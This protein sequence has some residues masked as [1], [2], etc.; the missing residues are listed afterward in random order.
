MRRLRIGIIGA[1]ALTEWA[2]LP[3]LSGPDA[4]A[5]PDTGAWSGRRP[6]THA[7]IRYQAPAQPDVVALCDAD[8]GLARRVGEVARIRAIYS[9]WRQML[10]E[11]PLDAVLCTAGPDT[12]AEVILAMR[13][14]LGPRHLWVDG[15]PAPTAQAAADLEKLLIPSLPGRGLRL[16]CARPLRQA[17]AH[18]AA[19]RMLERGAIGPSN[20]LMLRWGAS[21]FRPREVRP[22]ANGYNGHSNGSAR[23]LTLDESWSLASSYAAADLLLAFAMPLR[24]AGR[25]PIRDAARDEAKDMRHNGSAAPV[26]VLASERAGVATI[27]LHFADG[28]SAVALFAPA[29]NWSSPL[30]RLEICGTEGR[31]IVCEGGRRLWVHEPREAARLLEPPGLAVQVS[32]ANVAG[33]AED[34]KEFL[35]ACVV[36]EKIAER[37]STARSGPERSP[38]EP[39]VRALRVIEAASQSLGGGR[40]IHI[41]PSGTHLPMAE[42]LAE[43]PGEPS[44]EL[45]P[46]ASGT[47]PLAFEFE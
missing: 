24:E 19:W 29:E 14:A 41:E 27:W 37:T 22:A 23:P 18:R 36:D 31:G 4:V 33:M 35:G 12:A 7:E 3:V 25:E 6:G 15:P 11:V 47:L 45:V 32:A 26:A 2:L 42:T 44:G 30:P 38:L 43:L 16:W 10:R 5:P 13:G 46:L 17:A 34:L 39:A 20:G 1:G 40:V 28:A 9:D 8:A 21:L